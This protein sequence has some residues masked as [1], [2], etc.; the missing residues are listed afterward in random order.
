M[1]AFG[2][3]SSFKRCCIMEII[4][5]NKIDVTD[6]IHFKET[7]GTVIATSRSP[8]TQRIDFV[9]KSEDIIVVRGEILE[10]PIETQNILVLG[11]IQEIQK[12]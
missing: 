1:K 4:F 5:E 12:N 10:I 8:S 3:Q 7:I 9:L 11:V 2:L 6:K